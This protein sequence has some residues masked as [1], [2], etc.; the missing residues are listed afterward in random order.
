MLLYFVIMTYIVL[1]VLRE[2][3]P[4][5]FYLFAG[6]LFVLSQLAW[7]LLGKVICRVR[8]YSF[9][10]FAFKGGRELDIYGCA[11]IQNTHAK[12]DGSW[13]ATLLETAS[14]GALFLGWR[15]ITEGASQR[16]SRHM[17]Y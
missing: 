14:V 8:Q 10:F 4:M 15:S 3:R 13:I 16:V 17:F 12:I 9:P 11:A 7:Y 2:R 1:G 6:I 5:G